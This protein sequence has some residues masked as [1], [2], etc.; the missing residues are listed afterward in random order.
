LFYL[1]F[2][3]NC[4]P[5]DQVGAT[6]ATSPFFV[7]LQPTLRGGAAAATRAG[8]QSSTLKTWSGRVKTVWRLVRAVFDPP[9]R[10][11]RT[12]HHLI[13]GFERL[14]VSCSEEALLSA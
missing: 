11:H 6:P 13:T 1:Y 9:L 2:V 4:P 12:D 3:E 7:K 10:I 14:N 5:I 8:G